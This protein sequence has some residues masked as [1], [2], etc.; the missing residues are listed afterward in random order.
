MN[1]VII[2]VLLTIV[3][4]VCIGLLYLCNT[5]ANWFVRFVKWQL[6]RKKSDKDLFED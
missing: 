6:F 4:I 2:A 5:I 3:A 1:E